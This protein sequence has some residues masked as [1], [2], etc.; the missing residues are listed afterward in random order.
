[1]LRQ[2]TF[3]LSSANVYKLNC[4]ECDLQCVI[5]MKIRLRTRFLKKK[6]LAGGKTGKTTSHWRMKGSLGF[7]LWQTQMT[8]WGE[9]NH[10]KCDKCEE[11]QKTFLNCE[12]VKH[13]KNSLK[14][15][16]MRPKDSRKWIK[17]TLKYE[18]SILEFDMCEVRYSW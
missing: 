6:F 5:N 18:V 2:K 8:T 11:W 7:K 4:L 3:C 9:G 12:K 15:W 1:M 10:V 17:M 13:W 16:R 14:M